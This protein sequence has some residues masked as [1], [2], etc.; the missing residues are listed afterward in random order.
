[1]R[2]EETDRRYTID[3]IEVGSQVRRYGD[4]FRHLYT[5]TRIVARREFT[6]RRGLEVVTGGD[7]LVYAET[8]SGRERIFQSFSLRRADRP[9]D[10]FDSE[11]LG[12]VVRNRIATERART[13]NIRERVAQAEFE[14]NS[15]LRTCRTLIAL[16]VK[17]DEAGTPWKAERE[18]H[19]VAMASERFGFTTEE[20]FA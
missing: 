9:W 18:L 4:P 17:L 11:M 12:T 13:R 14:R 7:T 6:N 19:K 16:A 2:I 5:V 8:W 15:S 20:L 3:G 10:H 1:M